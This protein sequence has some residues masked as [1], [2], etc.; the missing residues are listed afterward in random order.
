MSDP[1]L[2][3]SKRLIARVACRSLASRG[4][5]QLPP[6]SPRGVTLAPGQLPPLLERQI[7]EEPAR[8][9]AKVVASGSDP[10]PEP[11]SSRGLAPVATAALPMPIAF[12]IRPAPPATAHRL[13]GAWRLAGRTRGRSGQN[14]QI[15]LRKPPDLG[16]AHRDPWGRILQL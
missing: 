7:C 9:S 10:A 13:G 15:W 11:A 6:W 8:W 14:R 12:Q 16:E 1:C 2:L 5:G 4:A 3:R